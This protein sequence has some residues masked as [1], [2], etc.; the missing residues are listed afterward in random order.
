MRCASTDILN[1]SVSENVHWWPAAS[2]LPFA[3]LEVGRLHED[4]GAVL[5]GSFSVSGHVV[6][7]HHHRVRDLVATGRAASTA[8]IA[9]DHRGRGL[10]LAD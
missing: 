2:A 8:Y 7:A 10:R 4:A 5:P 6:Y 1:A 9:D 3:L